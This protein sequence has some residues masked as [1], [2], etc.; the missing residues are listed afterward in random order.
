MPGEARGTELQTDLA[1]ADL[2]A[3]DGD[4][5]EPRVGLVGHPQAP[6][7]RRRTVAG[8][9]RVDGRHGEVVEGRVGC[10]QASTTPGA[11][12]VV[13]DR[14]AVDGDGVAGEGHAAP[15][16]AGV[17]PLEEG[18]LD[19]CAGAQPGAASVSRRDV[20]GDHR[21]DDLAGRS[22]G[23]SSTLPAGRVATNLGVE[24]RQRARREQ[25]AALARDGPI[26]PD[27]GAGGG[28]PDGRADGSTAIAR[29][30][31]RLAV[32]QDQVADER[33]AA[34]GE[35]EDALTPCAVEDLAPVG[36]GRTLDGQQ[37]GAR[38]V[39]REGGAD[40]DAGAVEGRSEGDRARPG[41]PRAGTWPRRSPL[42]ACTCRTCRH[43]LRCR[44]CSRCCPS[45]C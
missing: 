35:V 33:T 37:A 23:H 41:R 21:P 31:E 26:V 45:R 12:T 16:A 6:T 19:G 1:G 4:V 22:G 5:L 20:A 2:V 40:E 7:V 27:R 8:D 10:G 17:V 43:R 3:V 18:L 24:H 39:D 13:A 9:G 29:S 28:E 15:G 38:D 32:L 36:A 25:P 44:G 42:G 11:G 14:G 34:T 30:T